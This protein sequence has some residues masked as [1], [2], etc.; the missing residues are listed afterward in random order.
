M[1]DCNHNFKAG[2]LRCLKCNAPWID[3]LRELEAFK[4]RTNDAFEN[5]VWSEGDHVDQLFD[6]IYLEQ[7]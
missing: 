3:V 6:A 7:S 4:D 1:N 2:F 5:L